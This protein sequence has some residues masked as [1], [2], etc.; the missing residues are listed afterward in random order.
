[1]KSDSTKELMIDNDS[2]EDFLK[3]LDTHIQKI[4]FKHKDKSGITIDVSTLKMISIERIKSA[5]EKHLKIQWNPPKEVTHSND[6]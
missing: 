3:E 2:V 6:H 1:M 5:L 4:K